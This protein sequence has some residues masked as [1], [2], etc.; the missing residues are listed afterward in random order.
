MKQVI[1]ITGLAQSMGLE[2]SRLL[3]KS[4]Y[5]IAGFDIC[6]DDIDKLR[7]ELDAAGCDNL[8]EVMDVTD[9]PGVLGFRD[10]VLK[11]FGQVDVVLSNVGIGFFGPFEEVNLEKALKCLEIN[12]I[13][14]AAI[15]QAFIP[16]M[17]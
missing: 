8:I 7:A 14:T 11:K 16:S 13:G 9:R 17:R 3:A 4:G 6:A 1:V 10:R 2:T 15:F 12:V 5:S